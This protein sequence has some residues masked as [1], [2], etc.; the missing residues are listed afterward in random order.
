MDEMLRQAQ[1]ALRR[2]DGKTALAIADQILEHD[3]TCSQAWLIAMQCFQL[4]YPI[5]QYDAQNELNCAR[6]AIRFAS[7]EKKYGVRK[8]VY[9]FLMDKILDVLCRDADVLAD[10]R[11]LL[12]FYQRTAYFD[13]RGA[14]EKTRAHDKDVMDAVLR[15]FS[16]CAQLFDFI[17]DSAVRGNAQL[18]RKAAEIA[19]QWQKTY[20]LVAMRVGLYHCEMPAGDIR[21]ALRTYARYLRAVRDKEEIMK[22]PVPFNTIGEDQLSYL[23]DGS[24]S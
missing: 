9:L 4:I 6:Y 19:Q 14:A 10:A 5:E 23:F 22:A 13:A 20:S 24:D 1:E 2:K 18:N 17:P 3:E 21:E 12:S 15:S 7:K 11:E 16:Y 8:R